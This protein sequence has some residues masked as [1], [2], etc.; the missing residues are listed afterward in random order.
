MEDD[1][2]WHV[3]L[4]GALAAP[5]AQGFKEANVGGFH[6]QAIAAAPP[7][8][9]PGTAIAIGTPARRYVADR[10]S[11]LAAV[12]GPNL[13]HRAEPH[14]RAAVVEVFAQQTLEQKLIEEITPH[15]GETQLSTYGIGHELSVDHLRGNTKKALASAEPRRWPIMPASTSACAPRGSRSSSRRTG[16]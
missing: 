7:A 11:P 6:G 3:L 16:R 13:V 10:D 2:G 4:G 15:A 14:Q 5:G 9:T 12:N 8:G 1:V